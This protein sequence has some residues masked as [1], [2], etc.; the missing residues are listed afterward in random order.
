[1]YAFVSAGSTCGK[2]SREESIAHIARGIN[3]ALRAT[4][5][6]TV[7]LENM[8]RQVS[9]RRVTER[10]TSPLLPVTDDPYR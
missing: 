9:R 2:I 4:S 8:S 7:L 10:V 1:M 6:V 3:D 5:G